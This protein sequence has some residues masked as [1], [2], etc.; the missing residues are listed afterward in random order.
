M[1]IS[2]NLFFWILLSSKGGT[3]VMKRKRII[4]TLMSCIFLFSFLAVA[5]TAK[6]YAATNLAA[7]KLPTASSTG[8]KNLSRAT[9]G[10]ISTSN[11]AD[12][13]TASGL[14]WIQIDLG[15]SY[16]IGDIKLWHYYGDTRMYHDVIVMVSNNSS[17]T[18]G[19]YTIVYN[20]DTNSSA[21]FGAGTASEYTE[22]S[23]GKDIPLSSPVSGRYVRLYSSGSTANNYTHYG[24]V[25]V[26]EAQTPGTGNL[27]ANVLPTSPSAGWLNLSYAADGIKSASNYADSNTGTGLQYIQLDL[28]TSYN[29]NDI[30]LWH[31]FGDARTYHDVIVMV[32]N[33]AGF[34]SGNYT[35]V[36]NNDQNGNAGFGN[37]LDSEYAETSSGLDIPFT[38]SVNAR[39]VRLYS[40]GSTV[41]SCNHYGEVEVYAATSVVLPAGITLNKTSTTINT[42]ATETLT[43]TVAPPNATDKTVTW[44]SSNTAVA[45]VNPSGTVT[46]VAAGTATI[47]AK[48]VNNITATCTVTVS[49]SVVLPTGIS[50]NKT[51]TTINIGATDT[52]TATVTPANATDK[53]VTWTSSNTAVATVSSSGTVTGVAAGTATITAKT[54]NNLT[55][56]CA[57]TVS[58]SIVLPTG[59]SL[60]KTS[61]TISAGATE[62]LT[63]TVTPTNATDKTVTWTSSNTAAATVSSSGTITG[64]AAGAATITAKTVNN[65]TATCTVT[66]TAVSPSTNLAS[67]ILPTSPSTGW[68]NLAYATDGKKTTSNYADSGTGTGLQYIQINLGSAYNLSDIKL[69]HYYGDTRMYHDVIV[70]V[71]NNASFTAGSYTIVYSNDQN[72]SAGFGTGS[73]SE[74]TET[75]AGKDIPFSAV[76]A[77]YVRLYTNGSTVN[78]YNHYG[79]VEVYGTS[80]TI[81]SVTAWPTASD[82]TYGQ[83]LGNSNLTGGAA[84]V[85]GTFAFSSPTTVPNAGT[86]QAF[87]AT[88]TPADTS[89]Y[90]TVTGTISI[91]VS[92]ATPTVTKWP[93]ASDIAAGQTL[94][95]SSLTGGTASVAGTFAFSSPNTVPPL[96]NNQSFPAIF[97]PASTQNYNTVN[98]TISINVVAKATPAVTAWPTASDISVGQNLGSSVLTGGTAS[99][100]GTFA[101]NS[102]STIP[103]AGNNQ[104]FA[105]TFTPT[106]TTHYSTVTGTISINVL[107]FTAITNLA[108]GIVPTAS[109][110]GWS[111]LAAA[112]D[113]TKSVSNYADSGS[114]SGLQY[115]QLNLGKQSE[116]S[117]IKLWHYFG[118]PRIYR[119]VIVQLSNDP[120]FSSGVTTVYNNDTNNS[121]G[122]GTGSNSEYGE[123]SGGLTINF[124]TVTAQYVRCYSNGSSV[125]NYN[126]VS[127]IEVYNKAPSNAA[128]GNLA[129]GKTVTAST[130]FANLANAVDGNKATSNYA[131]SSPATGLQW[132]QVDLGGS[133]GV[134]YIKLYHYYGDTRKYHDVIVQLS[135]DPNF[136]TGVTTVFSNDTD[137][138]SGLGKG[139][140]SEYT[141]TGLGKEIAFAPTNA[142]YIRC[143]S[144]GSTANAYNHVVEIE[145]FAGVADTTPLH[146]AVS[147]LITPTYDG[148][149]QSVHPSVVYFPNGWH[150]Y[151]YWMAHTPYPFSN[152]RYENPSILASNDGFT[153]VTPSG[154]TNPLAPALAIGHNN[155]PELVYNPKTDQLYLYWLYTDDATYNVT[156]L[157]KSSNGT[158]WTSP[159]T[160]I[161]DTRN[162]YSDLSPTIQVGYNTQTG[163]WYMYYVNVT[164]ESNWFLERR[165]SS[166]GISWSSPATLSNAQFGVPGAEIWH[167]SI[168]YIP[169]QNEY[170]ALAAC[171]PNGASDVSETQLY[172]L[173]SSDGLNWASYATPVIPYGI[174]GSW[175]DFRVYRAS[176][177]YDTTNDAFKVWYSGTNL[178][179]GAWREGYT[180]NTYE[181]MMYNLLY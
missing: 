146:N 96:G 49:Q 22:T 176:F 45:T 127:E 142:R 102:P 156:K 158:T 153:W 131:D 10:T 66:V 163:L 174:S 84:S 34:T 42:G 114:A 111:S 61:T 2:F 122:R 107:A 124:N 36:Y 56:T 1:N 94:G 39:Y 136:A 74:Y 155:D 58:Q 137:N 62:T 135:N 73:S 4:S 31:Y 126:H 128:T 71:S 112:T 20:N 59:I 50:L 18:A 88:F 167:I 51:S 100:P 144:N 151:K 33:N 181:N 69:W 47:T 116:I 35:V 8:F 178:A 48:T 60:N 145:A 65:L 149:G 93:T 76:N 38:A 28:G 103:A 81:P 24:E 15:A 75:S 109:S 52:L 95:S 46:G 44:T 165:Q 152:D 67:K 105:A 91:N 101:F 6:V 82:I 64:V 83:T 40:N 115:I 120:N 85:P 172:F 140:G 89:T 97:T 7:G 130:A 170:W 173:K 117:S 32:S 133:F 78:A 25:Q 12:S 123:S 5:P 106:D 147:P 68:K 175:D 41:N 30:K 9:D 16:S 72:N 169:S 98:G 80:K 125:N 110:T 14:Q 108:K 21:G 121:A 138:S 79:E 161:T 143:Y 90:S 87:A 148:S 57:V 77:Q 119:D 92:K 63:A 19:S 164:G 55:A 139:S 166:D 141:E 3:I 13:S 104:S 157:M 43:A 132:V 129:A 118:N 23:A 99:V 177:V 171:V 11:Y 70:M 17:F 160:V 180:Q 29:L 54:V 159:Q 113:G 86:N 53:T 162:A 168:Q 134:S 150:G 154:V 179:T 26:F 37:G 27:A